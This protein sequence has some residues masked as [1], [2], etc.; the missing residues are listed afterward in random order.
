MSKCYYV[1]LKI[2]LYELINNTEVVSK[3]QLHYLNLIN[4]IA[5]LMYEELEQIIFCLYFFNKSA[6]LN[7]TV[8]VYYLVMSWYPDNLNKLG[9]I[10]Y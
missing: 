4:I 7:L 3:K 9:S 8:I 2:T 6:V 10:L 1:L 5:Q